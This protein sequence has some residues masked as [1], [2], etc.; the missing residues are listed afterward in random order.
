MTMEE[1]LIERFPNDTIMQVRMNAEKAGRITNELVMRL[2]RLVARDNVQRTLDAHCCDGDQMAPRPSDWI[3]L[4]G[5]HSEADESL[6]IEAARLFENAHKAF[7]KILARQCP[8]KKVSDVIAYSRRHNDRTEKRTR[9]LAIACAERGHKGVGAGVPLLDDWKALTEMH[10]N[11]VPDSHI[12]AFFHAYRD[13]YKLIK[14]T[15]NAYQTHG[16]GKGDA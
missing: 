12:V 3:K 9:A 16:P 10:S 14:R 4:R 5:L 1:R 13:H 11:G 2:A 15:V 7:F 6:T 8:G